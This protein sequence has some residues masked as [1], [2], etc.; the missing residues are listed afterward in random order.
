MNSDG[1]SAIVKED[2]G[3]DMAQAGAGEIKREP[4]AEVALSR[5]LW[6]VFWCDTFGAAGAG[7]FIFLYPIY[8]TQLGGSGVEVGL[9]FSV[10]FV[11]ASIVYIPGAYLV[12]KYD[13]KKIMIASML[14]Q[15]VAVV[16]LFFSTDWTHVLLAEAVWYLTNI[17]SPAFITYITEAAPK[18][19]VMRSFGIIYA[20]PALAYVIAPALGALIFLQYDEIRMLFPFALVLRMMAPA[21]LL[22]ISSQI[23]KTVNQKYAGLTK[24]LFRMDRKTVQRITFLVLIAAILGIASPYLPLFL[25]EVRSFDEI[26]VEILGSVGFLGA[27]LLSIGLGTVGDRKGGTY[28]VLLTLAVFIGGCFALLGTD[29]FVAVIVAV[30]LLGIMT[31]VITILDSIAGMKSSEES[32]GGHLSVYLMA[33]SIA[34]APMPFIG[35]VLYDHVGPEWPFIVSAVLSAILAGIA[36]ARRD[37]TET[38]PA[39]ED[40]H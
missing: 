33:E 17:G 28:A 21:S 29:F 34:M 23:P 10:S 30:F 22:I 37:L 4:K 13:R 40:R 38:I 19:T 32:R 11:V 2:G 27:A 15:P 26:E 8:I 5:S 25:S 24:Q 14:T 7:L 3:R 18:D 36:L 35:G 39:G 31:T 9:I 1:S 20:G 6:G 12:H 16:I